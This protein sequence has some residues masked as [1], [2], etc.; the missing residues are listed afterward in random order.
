MN[1]FGIAV[2]AF[3]VN[4][5]EELLLV[6]R[7]ASDPH[8]PEAWEIPGGRLTPGEEPREGLKREA[9]EETNID[10]EIV[11]V[12]Y[13][14]H[15]T[16]DDGQKITMLS[17]L[18]RPK[19][20]AVRLS[21][22]HTKFAWVPLEKSLASLH[23]AFHNEVRIYTK[24]YKGSISRIQEEIKE[25]NDKR[26]WSDPS[27]IKDLMLNFDEEIG[28]MWNLIKWLDAEKQQEMIAAHKD[29]VENFIGDMLYL[30]LKIGYL[31]NVDS[32]KAISDVMKEYEQRFPADL[33]K[34]KNG[35]IFA[36]GIDLKNNGTEKLK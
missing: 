10:I 3:I 20:F 21:E 5:N 22:E 18:C 24:Y 12:L 28:E 16:R 4:N 19:S 13:A 2:K 34:G 33:V 29:E 1:D 26:E 8:T 11:N 25:F 17:F 27:C 15:F 36:G 7:R 9:R 31:C 6:K 30:I 35:N 32:E 14:H 23:P